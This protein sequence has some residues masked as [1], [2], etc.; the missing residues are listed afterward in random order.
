MKKKKKK[1]KKEGEK[2]KMMGEYRYKQSTIPGSAHQ[3][4][5]VCSDI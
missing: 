3:C 2:G 1:K 4:P 5:V